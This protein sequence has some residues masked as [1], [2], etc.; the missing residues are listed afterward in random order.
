MIE[1]R[2]VTFQYPGTPP[3]FKGFDWRVEAGEAWAVLG[4][5]GLYS[6]IRRMARDEPPY[7]FYA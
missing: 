1:L 2:S 4:P 7:R 3:I 5:S 6:L